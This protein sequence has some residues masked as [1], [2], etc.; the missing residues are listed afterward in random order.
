MITLF[1]TPKNFIEE[2]NIIQK[3][4]FSSWRSISD[5]IEIIIMGNSE[6]TKEA[7]LDINAK[8][9]PDIP[10]STKGTHIIFILSRYYYFQFF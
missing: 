2:S 9:I 10:L 6:G 7:A 5:E 3:N 4:A 1:S 8:F